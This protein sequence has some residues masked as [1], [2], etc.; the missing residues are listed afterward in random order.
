MINKSDHTGRELLM[1]NKRIFILLIIFFFS[2]LILEAQYQDHTINELSQPIP[3]VLVLKVKADQQEGWQ[4]HLFPG[5][6]KGELTEVLGQYNI[7]RAFPLHRPLYER[8]GMEPEK[9]VDLS[10]FYYLRFQD[11]FPLDALLFRLQRTGLFE[12]AEKIYPV[13]SLFIPNDE[14]IGFQ[15]YLDK[16]RAYQAWDIHQGDSN[17]IVGIVDSGTD[18]DHPDLKDNLAYNYNDPV[19]GYDNDNDG[20]V[21]NFCGWD[22][23]DWDNNPQVIP[24]GSNPAHGVHIC[25][26]A[27]ATTHNSTGVAGVGF[28]CRF[29]PVK[30]NDSHDHY[31]AGYEGIVYAADHGSKVI[32]CSWGSQQTAGQFGQDIINYATYNKDALV[33]AACGNSNN[34]VPFYP[35]SYENVLSVGATGPADERMFINA[36]YASSY[37]YYLDVCAPGSGIFNTWDFPNFYATMSGTSMA[38]AVASG[39]AAIIRSYYP[40]CSAGQAAEKLRATADIIDTLPA[41]ISF[42]GKLGTGRIN[43]YKALTDTLTPSIRLMQP[44][45]TDGNDSVFRMGDTLNLTGTF[46]N[47]LADAYDLNISIRCMN[48]GVQLI[49]SVFVVSTLTSGNSVSNINQAFR[50]LLLPGLSSDA[51]LIIKISYEGSGFHSFEYVRMDMNEDYVNI[52]AQ[53]ISTTLTSKGNVGFNDHWKMQGKGFC[54]KNSMTRL[55]SGGFLAGTNYYQ[56]SDVL[57]NS[58]FSGWD[59]DF[60]PVQKIHPIAVPALADHEYQSV[61]KDDG[62]GVSS[63]GLKV[64]QRTLYWDQPEDHQYVIHE[65]T[66]KNEGATSLA[67]LYAGLFIDW[68]IN[69]QAPDYDRTSWDATE[70]M[71]ITYSLSGGPYTGIS[72]VTNGP[73]KHYAFDNNGLNG[74]FNITDG[75]TA[76]EK[77]TALKSVRH[78]AGM[79]ALGNNVSDMVSSGPFLLQ[80]GDSVTLAFALVA[81]EQLDD[82]KASAHRAKQKYY[83]VEG[84]EE[85]TA[86]SIRNIKVFPNPAESVLNVSLNTDTP[87]ELCLKILDVTGKEIMSRKY[88][89]YSCG[90][91]TFTV[92]TLTMAAGMYFIETG[93]PSYPLR[94]KF[95][96]RQN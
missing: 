82:L 31:V 79:S 35:A 77:Y 68:D 16:I 27:A 48:Q 25:G 43:L 78:Q 7:K 90:W 21:D 86:D 95:I 70:R 53:D 96:K 8:P 4:Q 1:L 24:G 3:G 20:F 62:A 80:P 41:N 19:D 67:N 37:G 30:M 72:L 92:N 39:A 58:T 89:V 71:G 60:I 29:L 55:F 9:L 49:D 52:K 28:H 59:E 23:G 65:Y 15:Y 85:L 87:G 84:T 44:A 51:T 42:S 13:Q 66:L 93:S 91:N 6:F 12:Y 54:Y 76:Q 36:G 94:T 57:Y 2:P 10:L 83:P 40:E 33:V 45:F 22:V 61:Y 81:A 46:H 34:E 74:S 32:N 17:T 64:R 38:A 18:L 56:V 26:I 73:V 88:S 5:S 11:D 69:E 75:F 50:F 14:K 63:L 47:Y